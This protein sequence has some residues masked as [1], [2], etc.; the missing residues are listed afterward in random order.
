MIFQ[1]NNYAFSFVLFTDS[2]IMCTFVNEFNM[3]C[4][5]METETNDGFICQRV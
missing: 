3:L 1:R 2:K 4:E 5:I